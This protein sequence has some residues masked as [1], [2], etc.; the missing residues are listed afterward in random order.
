MEEDFPA[1]RSSARHRD[2]LGLTS[3]GSFAHQT[4]RHHL[5]GGAQGPEPVQ[6]LLQAGP[7]DAVQPPA[8]AAGITL[9]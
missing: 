1:T 5:S 3:S 2:H 7:P 4:D 6:A 9:L 8:A